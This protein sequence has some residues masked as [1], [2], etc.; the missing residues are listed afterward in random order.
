MSDFDSF[1]DSLD[2]T[3]SLRLFKPTKFS[4]NTTNSI[5]T[6]LDELCRVNNIYLNDF[7][8]CC[9][10]ITNL[11]TLVQELYILKSEQ[12]VNFTRVFILS[13]TVITNDNLQNVCETIQKMEHHYTRMIMNLYPHL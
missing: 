2:G 5:Q 6:L 3:F 7:N 9:N 4:I 10:K 13:S 11:D 8:I 12:S 1:F